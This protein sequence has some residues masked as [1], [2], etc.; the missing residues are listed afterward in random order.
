MLAMHRKWLMGV[1]S[2]ATEEQGARL[3]LYE[4]EI[5]ECVIEDETLSDAEV[6]R[7]IFRGLVAKRCDFSYANMID[8]VLERASLL[9]CDF[10]KA[11][12]RSA[13][14]AGA[15]FSGSDLA[16]ADFTDADLRGTI[17]RDCNLDG[18]WLINA[19]LRDADL[20][21]V[22]L[23]ETRFVG[24]KLDGV[25]HWRVDELE[26]AHFDSVGIG[27]VHISGDGARSYLRDLCLRNS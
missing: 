4:H 21:N 27:D 18:A 20:E 3:V 12:M 24:T 1:S 2:G 23:S 5:S 11:D 6:V 7:C 13:R 19:D 25:K 15:I 17:L 26:K 10:R 22:S 16:R 9:D 14:C 8:A